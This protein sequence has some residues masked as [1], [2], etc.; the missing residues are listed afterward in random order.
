MSIN[1][2][3][4]FIIDI[5]VLLLSPIRSLDVARRQTA[6]EREAE[7]QQANRLMVQLQRNALQKTLSDCIPADPLYF[8]SSSLC[9]LQP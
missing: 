3:W 1:G 8:H 6:E 4:L 9:A 7:R 2:L 5:N